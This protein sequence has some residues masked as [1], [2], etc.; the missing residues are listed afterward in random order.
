MQA[1]A[2]RPK[3]RGFEPRASRTPPREP[4]RTGLRLALSR[5]NL[6]LEIEDPRALGPLLITD[7]SVVLPDVRFPIDLTG[8]VTRFRHRR[9]KLTRLAVE[10]PTDALARHLAPRLRGLVGAGMPEVVIAPTSTGAVIGI[11][12]GVSALA[13]D[14]LLAPSGG[15]LRFVVDSPRGVG[16]GAPAFVVALRALATALRPHGSASDG[17]IVVEDAMGE[18]ARWVLPDAGARAPTVAALEIVLEMP[19]ALGVIALRASVDIAP[20]ALD[21]R[22]ISALELGELA[23]RADASALAGDLDEARVGY[24]AALERAPRH[25][26]IAARLAALDHA[27]GGREEAALATLIEA[28]PVVDAGILGGELLEA[29]GDH[30][31][32]HLAFARAATDEPYGPLAARVWAAAARVAVERDARLEALD[33]ALVRSPGFI[34]AR[35][36]RFAARLGVGDLKGALADAEHVE[37]ATRGAVARSAACVRAGEELR[38]RG[39]ASEAAGR[40]ERALRYGPGSAEALL[41]LARSLREMG[42]MARAIDLFT[43]ASA[44]AERSGEVSA[45]CELDLA[46][47]L[48]EHAR[49]LPAAVARV[50][51][52]PLL[53][54]E[55][56]EARICEARWR[57]ELADATGAARATAKLREAVEVLPIDRDDRGRVS[58]LLVEAARIDESE[59]GDSKAAHRDLTLALRLTPRTASIADG[60]KRLARELAAQLRDTPEPEPTRIRDEPEPAH[61][62]PAAPVIVP[63]PPAPLSIEE[64]PEAEQRVE[65]LTAQIRANPADHAAALELA[66]WL[67]ALG[68]DLDLLALLSARLDEAHGEQRAELVPMRREVLNRLAA[69]ARAE[70]RTSEAELYEM[71]AGVE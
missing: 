32:A 52:V 37:A 68:R 20:A 18:L 42:R 70:G 40:F 33:Q 38:G 55:T 57:A 31:A 63:T 2:R 64:G 34:E 25:P 58:R 67:A 7:V 30:G 60:L 15:D 19:R 27:E 51:R 69:S 29:V 1:G 21:R 61:E 53:A 43:R 4:E 49:D 54:K 16:L 65:Q 13:F 17:F 35:W 23:G 8:G 39:H 5:G 48:A 46:K 24:L 6:A 56:F 22:T 28:L 50:A 59:V 44:L 11:S 26:A 41:G 62:E 66:G 45:A 36:E 3:S 14:V 10:A 47:A 71:M 9:G 12:S